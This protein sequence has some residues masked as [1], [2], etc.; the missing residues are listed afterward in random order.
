MG[1][2]SN[3]FGD[4]TGMENSTKAKRSNRAVNSDR[5]RELVCGWIF[6]PDQGMLMGYRISKGLAHHNNTKSYRYE[7]CVGW[8]F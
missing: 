2:D 8:L 7:N 4:S 3:R 6:L 5:G 1:T